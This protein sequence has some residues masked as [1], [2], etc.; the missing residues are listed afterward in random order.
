MESKQII[1]AALNNGIQA[2]RFMQT[3]CARVTPNDVIRCEN[4]FNSTRQYA[5]ELAAKYIARFQ[6]AR[7]LA[8]S[9]GVMLNPTKSIDTFLDSLSKDSRYA[10][11]VLNF[12]TQRR[13]ETLRPNYLVAPLTITESR[14]TIVI[15]Q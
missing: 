3:E 9:V 1:K 5:N 6:E 8:R 14:R 15:D 10:Y 2:L 11:V 7:L 4:M 13:N 12:Q